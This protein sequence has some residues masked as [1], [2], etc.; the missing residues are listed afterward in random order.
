MTP[1]TIAATLRETGVSVYLS[2]QSFRTP[3]SYRLEIETDTKAFEI[4]GK[5]THWEYFEGPTL[6]GTGVVFTDLNAAI[7]H[8]LENNS[9][10]QAYA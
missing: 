2:R 3:R 1:E 7:T 9:K 4:L 6:S 10:T 8:G 5:D